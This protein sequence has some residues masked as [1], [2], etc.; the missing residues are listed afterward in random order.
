[1]LGK[2]V[3]DAYRDGAVTEPAACPPVPESF[4]PDAA[5]LRDSVLAGVPDD[6]AA[7]TL[8]AWA[9]LFGLVSFELF[10]QWENVVTDRDA[11]F[12]HAASCLGRM[13]GLPPS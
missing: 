8:G 9:G 12:S 13:A 2:I 3:S 6:V 4:G 7:R 1:V 10:G 5:R 11:F